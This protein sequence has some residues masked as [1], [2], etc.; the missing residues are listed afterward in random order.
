MVC[1]TSD[2]GS[3]PTGTKRVQLHVWVD[4]DIAEYV[5]ERAFRERRSRGKTVESILRA[6]K[7]MDIPHEPILEERFYQALA[8]APSVLAGSEPTGEPR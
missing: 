8:G 2:T 3:F 4:S 1:M 6:E 7:A 5:R